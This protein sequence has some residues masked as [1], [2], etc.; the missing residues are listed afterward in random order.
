MGHKVHPYGFRIGIIRG[1][2]AKWYDEKNYLETLHDDLKLRK[3]IKRRLR[4]GAVARV[5]MDRQGND[6]VV[7]IFTA[8]PGIVIGRGGQRAE[9][10]RSE[11]EKLCGK[12]VKL[13]IKEVEQ[14][15]T[16][17]MLV[18]RNIA[19]SLER[20]IA[21]RRAMKQAAFKTR[22]A[23]AKGIRIS[24]AGRLGG[25]E[26]ARRE[27]VREGQL[28]LHTLCA[29]IDYGVAEA[30]TTMGNIGVKVWIYKGNIIPE[31]RRESVTTETSEVSKV[32]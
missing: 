31:V 8:R 27:T 29:D 9:E 22:Q 19:D 32:P 30:A 25:A 15:E 12:K 23:G 28:P 5:E 26:I 3:E 20:R 18:A 17:A 14:P 4:E 7:T 10:L 24:C 13:S 16:E 6:I 1:W 21:F 11:L 2:R